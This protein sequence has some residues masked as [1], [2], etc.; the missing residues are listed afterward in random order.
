MPTSTNSPDGGRPPA[1]FYA[2]LAAAIG[3]VTSTLT[4]FA[5]FFVL[6]PTVITQAASLDDFTFSLVFLGGP[7]MLFCGPPGCLAGAMAAGPGFLVARRARR[8]PGALLAVL[9]VALVV[10]VVAGVVTQ[11]AMLQVYA[12]LFPG[13]ISFQPQP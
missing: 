4:V 13:G 8:S 3:A 2:L 5:A 12:L 10:G 9:A 1:L 7:H 6:N 11:W